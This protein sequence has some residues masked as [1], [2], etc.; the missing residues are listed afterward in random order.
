MKG[1]GFR[2]YHIGVYGGCPTLGVLF[3][4]V[5][6]IRTIVYGGPCWGTRVLGS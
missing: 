2:V 5:P 1:L 3:W 4:G 6:I